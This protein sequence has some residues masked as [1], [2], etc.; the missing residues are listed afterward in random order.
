MEQANTPSS[1]PRWNWLSIVAIAGLLGWHGWMTLGLFGADDP[2]GVMLNEQPVV[3]GFHPLHQY[4]GYLGAQALLETGRSVCYDP[5]FQIGY[6]KTPVFDSGSRSAEFFMLLTGGVYDPSAYK[7]G[8]ACLVFLIP[9]LI[10][11][12]SASS[13]LSSGKTLLAT[14]FG[15]LICWGVPARSLLEYGE[16]D[17]LFAG[18]CM[19][20]VTGLL[21]RFDRRPGFLCGLGLF[22]LAA[23]GWYLHPLVFGLFVPIFLVFYLSA[24]VRPRSLS[25][26]IALWASQLGALAVNAVWLR[27]WAVHWWIRAP[28]PPGTEVLPHRT[29]RTFWEAS[30]WGHLADRAL[31]VFLLV[32]AA[33]GL[34]CFH[35]SRKCRI[36]S[37]TL[38]LG[39]TLLLVIAFL[40]ISL[41]PFARM[42]TA[43]T[44]VPAL[45]FATLL[46]AE[47]C[48]GVSGAFAKLVPRRTVRLGLLLPTMTILAA[49]SWPHLQI[50]VE[51]AGGTEPLQ[52]GLS[53]EQVHLVRLIRERT[54]RDGRILWEDRPGDRYSSRW[55]A[56]LPLLTDRWFIG[57]LDPE[58]AIEHSRAGL[59]DAML[60]GRAVSQWSD[61]ALAE[62]CRKYNVGWVCTSCSAT[63][64]RFSDW[65]SGVISALKIDDREGGYLFTMKRAQTSYAIHGKADLVSAS[66]GRLT[67]A[68]VV[69][70]DGKV[71]LSFHY[72]SGLRATPRR[73]Q[74]EREPDIYD[75]IPLMRLR[76]S[77]PVSRLTITWDEH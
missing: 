23:L 11:L 64:K 52:I 24:G 36:N 56:L 44:L 25:W 68:N 2:L 31:T 46:A 40:G 60:G 73:V 26:H 30:L 34:A 45:W 10:V 15:I 39:T 38:G 42:R 65:K 19:L 55:T 71:V 77:Q 70:E 58:G 49:L 75:A 27:D 67:F 21:I 51:R 1:H 41:E 14:F 5:R 76:V 33:I 63:A 59:A 20:A 7:I 18:V 29:L 74:I 47:G 4:H 35:H 62:Y 17:M 37:R 3:S 13:G 61:E 6:P 48:A 54:D 8:V 50:F 32:L 9:F 22:L 69:P 16:L 72:Q 53:D 57:G 66:G 28:L 43:G 12:A